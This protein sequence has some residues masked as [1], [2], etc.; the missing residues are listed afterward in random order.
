MTAHRRPAGMIRLAAIVFASALLGGG[1]A[2]A[3]STFS[4]VPPSHPFHDEIE[5]IAQAGITEGYADGTYRPADPVSRG[6][7]AAFMSRGF[8]RSDVDDGSIPT[9]NDGTE[10]TVAAITM[11]SG[12]TSGTGGYIVLNGTADG[13]FTASD[14]PCY[15]RTELYDVSA[16]AAE[17]VNI[18]V[19]GDHDVFFGTTFASASSTWRFA[20]PPNALRTYRLNVTIN[21]ASGDPATIGGQITGTYVPFDT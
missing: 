17:A 7:M 18:D 4:D 12:A 5:L 3:G 1:V 2:L 19:V 8:G 9:A 10:Y 13:S 21:T 16:A 15:V 6:A 20:I 11:A 14:C